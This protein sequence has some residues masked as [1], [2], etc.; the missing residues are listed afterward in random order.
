M[1]KEIYFIKKVIKVGGSL[2][3]IIPEDIVEITKLV[4]GDVTKLS[5]TK[6]YSL[7]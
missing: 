5:I 1:E 3:V 6:V 2:A 7:K 4:A